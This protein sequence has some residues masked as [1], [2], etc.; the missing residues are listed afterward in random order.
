MQEGIFARP[1]ALA[2]LLALASLACSLLSVLPTPGPLATPQPTG[3]RA[4][5]HP[6]ATPDKS[7]QGNDNPGGT[8]APEN[9]N[10]NENSPTQRPADFS[11]RYEWNE[12]SL[13]PPY[14]YEYIIRVGP[15][16]VGAVVMIPDYPTEGVPEWREAFAV[17]ASTLDALYALMVAQGVFTTEWREAGDIPVGG[18]VEWVEVTANGRTV[19]VPGYPIEAQAEAMAP[20]YAAVNAL[21]PPD[22][23]A[24]LM[25]KRQEYVE[26]SGG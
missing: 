21:V 1:L 22:L 14:H 9:D 23:M 17:D 16:G 25:E 10:A 8:G 15:D 5:P 26:E 6:S 12:G 2:A 19:E 4:T 20:V 13:P 24:G 3:E 11:L 18:P 7:G